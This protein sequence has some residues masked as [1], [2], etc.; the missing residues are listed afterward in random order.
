VQSSIK[1]PSQTHQLHKRSFVCLFV[2]SLSSCQE[3][4][5][6]WTNPHPPRSYPYPS[7]PVVSLTSYHLFA[8]VRSH[9][10]E[11]IIV[12]PLSKDV[13]TCATRVG[14]EPIDHA[15]VITR[16]PLKRRFKCRAQYCSAF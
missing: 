6:F 14:V 7:L 16:S 3:K 5:I 1:A 4:A 8:G 10:A 13:T 12:K 2:P 15:I 11:V 9:Q